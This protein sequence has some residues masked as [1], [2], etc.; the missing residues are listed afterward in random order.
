LTKVDISAQVYKRQHDRAFD[1]LMLKVRS[2]FGSVS[3]PQASIFR[4]MVRWYRDGKTVM[5]GFIA[6]HRSNQHVSHHEMTFLNQPTQFNP[7]GEEIGKR[8][9]AAYFYLDVEKPRRGHYRFTFKPII[10]ADMD[11]DSPYTRQYMRMLEE[12]IRRRPGL[13]LWSHR[14]WK[15]N[16]LKVES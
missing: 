16:K 4:Q 1:R 13:W 12:T 8:M 14:R 15:W 5:C 2:R 10:P 3:V 9:N 7:G 11:E 6:D